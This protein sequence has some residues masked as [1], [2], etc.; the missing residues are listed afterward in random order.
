[1]FFSLQQLFVVETFSRGRG[2]NWLQLV[3]A[4]HSR[5]QVEARG[6][7]ILKMWGIC[8]VARSQDGQTLRHLWGCL[9]ISFLRL[10]RGDPGSKVGCILARLPKCVGFVLMSALF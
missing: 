10:V 7:L 4:E 3:Q 1:M 9:P 5:V 6:E 8:M 2:F